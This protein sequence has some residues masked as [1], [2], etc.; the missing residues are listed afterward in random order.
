MSALLI[1]WR[2]VFS[3][4][5]ALLLSLLLVL[6]Q[7]ARTDIRIQSQLNK[8]LTEQRNTA[9]TQ[10]A[11]QLQTQ[12]FFTQLG[13]MTNYEQQQQRRNSEKTQSVFK[14]MLVSNTCAGEPVPRS[15]VERLR[16]HADKIHDASS[17][18]YSGEFVGSLPSP[19]SSRQDD[20][21]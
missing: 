3:G 19:L 13:Q 6:L 2:W 12:K 15:V 7:Q 11:Q 20:L 1:H 4:L 17:G 10:L 14:K 21:R 16:Q 9:Q 5:I 18:A 8:Q